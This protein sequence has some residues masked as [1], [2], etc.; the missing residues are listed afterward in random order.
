MA[1]EAIARWSLHEQRRRVLR[2]KCSVDSDRTYR[3]ET[4]EGAGFFGAM[5]FRAAWLNALGSSLS[6]LS[7]AISSA[8]TMLG[9]DARTYVSRMENAINFRDDHRGHAGSSR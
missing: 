6:T 9:I 1:A 2:M 7:G 3:R 5:L 4:A 8:Y